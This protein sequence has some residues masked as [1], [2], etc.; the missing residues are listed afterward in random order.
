M[1]MENVIEFPNGLSKGEKLVE[2]CI[3]FIRICNAGQASRFTNLCQSIS[4]INLLCNDHMIL[5]SCC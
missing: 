2:S 4:I 3:G 5:W 1:N